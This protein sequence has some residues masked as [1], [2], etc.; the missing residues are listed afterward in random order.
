MIFK[1]SSWNWDSV[2]GGLCTRTI[3]IRRLRSRSRITKFPVHTRFIKIT[4]LKASVQVA[5]YLCSELFLGYPVSA[6]GPD[7][8]TMP[9]LIFALPWAGMLYLLQRNAGISHLPTPSPPHGPFLCLPHFLADVYGAGVM[10]FL[11]NMGSMVRLALLQ[12]PPEA[13]SEASNTVHCD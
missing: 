13:C 7:F 1:S 11:C 8:N 12:R 6:R 3:Q 2:P 9:K 4:S 10:Q 5:K